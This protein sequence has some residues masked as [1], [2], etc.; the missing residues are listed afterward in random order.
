MPK[1]SRFIALDRLD[2]LADLLTWW[3]K[4]PETA[5]VTFFILGRT[6]SGIAS[7]RRQTPLPPGNWFPGPRFGIFH[8]PRPPPPVI[9]PAGGNIPAGSGGRTT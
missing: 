1:A 2:V 7:K 6:E 8:D 9:R 4:R 3:R 5:E